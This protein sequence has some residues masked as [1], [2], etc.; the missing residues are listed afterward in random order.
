MLSLYLFWGIVKSS[1]ITIGITVILTFHSCFSSQ[2][3]PSFHLLLILLYDLP[4]QKSSL[5]NRV[6][7]FFFWLS[8]GLVIWPS[9]GD[10][11]V[12]QNLR[13]LYWFHSPGCIPGCSY[14]TCSYGQIEISGT[15]LSVSVSPSCCASHY[16][17]FGLN[18]SIRFVFI[19]T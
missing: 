19:T 5:F 1:P 4:E 10:P 16:S 8:L 11:I 12:F 7:L 17:L 18:F 15:M 6:S 2:E 9:V 13:E 3:Y 14:T